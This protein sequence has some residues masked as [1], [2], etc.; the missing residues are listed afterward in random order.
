MS[1]ENKSK[2]S[3]VKGTSTVVATPPS[4]SSSFAKSR[5]NT[6]SSLLN[7]GGGV[8]SA[9]EKKQRV[10]EYENQ[11]E[12]RGVISQLE[13][14]FNRLE[15]RLMKM[16]SS[17]MSAEAE[18]STNGWVDTRQETGAAGAG[19]GPGFFK[20][21]VAKMEGFRDIESRL[22]VLE[23]AVE[24]EHQS[25]LQMLDVLLETQTA[26]R[27]GTGTANGTVTG[28]SKFPVSGPSGGGSGTGGER[29]SGEKKKSREEQGG[30][31]RER[32]RRS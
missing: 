18:L 30:R 26:R 5:M 23:E 25:S 4:P 28:E 19:M 2:A 12:L 20:Q 31:G 29:R 7:G 17:L 16:E 8:I 9:A 13:E 15:K 10:A 3:T 14:K 1:Q 11:R 27:V 6:S 22:D 21:L 24:N 32:G